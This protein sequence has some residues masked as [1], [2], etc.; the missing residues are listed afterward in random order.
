MS[1][2]DILDQIDDVIH[3]NGRSPDAMHWTAEPPKPPTLALDIDVEAIERAF[4]RLGEQMQIILRAF[5]S[6]A[7]QMARGATVIYQAFDEIVRMPGM[8]DLAQAE[9]QRRRTMK[10]EYAR[11]RRARERR[12]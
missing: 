10:S 4:A 11:R 12:R 9:R 8:S 2:R 5:S 6:A 1:D 3:W 7:E